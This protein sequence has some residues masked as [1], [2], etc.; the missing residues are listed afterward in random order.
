LLVALEGLRDREPLLAFL[1]L[2]LGLTFLG[3]AFLALVRVLAA[4]LAARRRAGFSGV[5]SGA[6]AAAGIAA[7]CPGLR[8]SPMLLASWDR[9]SE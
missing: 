1:A 8:P 6:G 4:L 2:A 7:D 5:V 9:R 3:L